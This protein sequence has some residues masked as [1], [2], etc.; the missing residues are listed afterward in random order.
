MEKKK[1]KMM[2]RDYDEG[3]AFGKMCSLFQKLGYDRTILE[4]DW[5]SRVP[6]TTIKIG[7]KKIQAIIRFISLYEWEEARIIWRT[8][9][10]EYG[11]FSFSTQFYSEEYIVNNIHETLNA[12]VTNLESQGDN[13]ASSK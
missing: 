13:D 11:Q 6:S 7:N 12:I 3:L 10:N 9:E 5:E 1:I 8:K 4:M 2:T